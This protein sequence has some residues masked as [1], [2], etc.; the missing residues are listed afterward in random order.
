VVGARLHWLR[1][2]HFGRDSVSM[3]SNS[4]SMSMHRAMANYM[5]MSVSML[6]FSISFPLA[7]VTRTMVTRTMVTR[8]MEPRSM[9]SRTVVSGTVVS[10]TV[11]SRTMVSWTVVNRAMMNG[12]MVSR[13]MMSRSS[14][15]KRIARDSDLNESSG[16]VD[17][18]RAVVGFMVSANC[19]DRLL[20]VLCHHCILVNVRHLL[21]NL[22]WTVHLPWGTGLHWG[23]M[24][25]W[26]RM[27]HMGGM[28]MPKTVTYGSFRI[29]LPLEDA[30][31]NKAA[32]EQ[33]SNHSHSH[34]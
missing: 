6:R 24:T 19:G 25:D 17:D 32:G 30:C 4:R 20:T 8:S 29:S 12:T 21:A 28:A 33:V 23:L 9:V 14:D 2:T 11:V 31:S 10:R 15:F 3:V 7:R 18:T 13:T 27:G 1:V 34:F 22:S 5:T 16:V 26:W